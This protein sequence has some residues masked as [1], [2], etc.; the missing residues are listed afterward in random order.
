MCPPDQKENNAK[1]KKDEFIHSFLCVSFSIL[2]P[3]QFTRE[4]ALCVLRTFGIDEEIQPLC[5]L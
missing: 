2:R 3:I 5:L 1:G 4:R